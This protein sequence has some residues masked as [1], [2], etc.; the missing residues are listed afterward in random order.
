MTL[1]GRGFD[2][3]RRAADIL[4]LLVQEWIF[5]ARVDIQFW[6]ARF[7]GFCDRPLSSRRPILVDSSPSGVQR[8][9][10]P[11]VSTGALHVHTSKC[12]GSFCN[13]NTSKQT[14]KNVLLILVPSEGSGIIIKGRRIAWLTIAGSNAFP[15]FWFGGNRFTPLLCN[16]TTSSKRLL[17]LFANNAKG[18][19]A[20]ESTRERARAS[21]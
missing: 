1:G 11:R 2:V 15:S 8:A 5:F 20:R 14:V 13:Q 21:I 19:K 18:S 7:R 4:C 6:S 10:H 17:P 16:Q 9:D 3:I 12:I